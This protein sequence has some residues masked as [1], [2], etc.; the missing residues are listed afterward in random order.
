QPDA[1][2][3]ARVQALKP[4]ITLDIT[5]VVRPYPHAIAG[6]VQRQSH[7]RL[8]DRVVPTHG[9][10]LRAQL[11]RAPPRRRAPRIRRAPN[12]A[13]SVGAC[14]LDLNPHRDGIA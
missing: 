11:Q 3:G 4:E 6:R 1:E 14:A 5:A 7:R 13:D 12:G 10:R 2:T 9:A 8:E